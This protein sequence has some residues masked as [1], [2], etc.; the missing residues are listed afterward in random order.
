MKTLFIRCCL[1][2]FLFIAA[3]VSSAQDLQLSGSVSWT[4][5]GSRIDISADRIINSRLGGLSGTLRLE[6]WATTT[7]YSGGSIYGYIFGTRTLDQLEGGYSYTG[8]SGYVPYRAPPSGNYYTTITLEEY[9]YGSFVIVDYVNFDGTTSFGGV[10]GD[11][12]AG[13]GFNGD[14]SLGGNV[15]W[16]SRGSKV[17]LRVGEV[18]N[19]RGGGRSGS[20]RLRLWATSTPYYGGSIYGYVLGTKSIPRLYGGYYLP[21]L[22]VTTSFRRPHSGYYYTTLTLEEYTPSGWVIVDYVSFPGYTRF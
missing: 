2:S 13:D 15:S 6:I 5:V 8:I 22:S 19:D 7:P 20:L 4:R 21:N 18:S 3:A 11:G 16:E 10:A 12:S 1:V 14:L 17:T 9:R